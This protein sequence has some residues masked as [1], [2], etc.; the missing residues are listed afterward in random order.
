MGN[1]N[2]IHQS[3]IAQRNRFGRGSTA[4]NRDAVSLRNWI[5][6]LTNYVPT[7]NNNGGRVCNCQCNTG[8]TPSGAVYYGPT[9]ATAMGTPIYANTMNSN[10]TAVANC[11]NNCHG[12]CY[13]NCHGNCHSN[14]N[15][16]CRINSGREDT[17]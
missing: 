7:V 12:N 4:N 16:D 14:C 8:A 10:I 3:I 2:T 17:D 5:N 9:I 13:S 1:Y 15:C 11:Y 6:D